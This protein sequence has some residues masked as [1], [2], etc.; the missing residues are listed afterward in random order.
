[1][2]ADYNLELRHLPGT[3]NQ[4]DLLSRWPDHNDRSNDNEQVT[5]LPDELF[6]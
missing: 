1:M 6:A 3:K 2:L 5:V 4:A